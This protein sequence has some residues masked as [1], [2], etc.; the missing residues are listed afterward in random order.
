MEQ[1]A[2]FQQNDSGYQPKHYGGAI[3][4]DQKHLN[5]DDRASDFGDTGA[6]GGMNPAGVGILTADDFNLSQI[7]KNT[8]HESSIEN[9]LQVKKFRQLIR[10]AD[11]NYM[12]QTV[13]D[14]FGRIWMQREGVRTDFHQVW[15]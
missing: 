11:A 10:A 6:I 12:N 5:Q 8:L 9:I 13:F 4:H 3:R 1:Y 2:G 7:I 14:K 15:V